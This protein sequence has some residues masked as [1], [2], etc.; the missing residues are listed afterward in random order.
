MS[1]TSLELG[2]IETVPRFSALV[3]SHKKSSEIAAKSRIF[4]AE[5]PALDNSG[6]K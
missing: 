4:R 2:R 5:K 3:E 1:I 6:V